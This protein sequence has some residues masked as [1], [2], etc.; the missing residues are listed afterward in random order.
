M[1]AITITTNALRMVQIGRFPV[2]TTAFQGRPLRLLILGAIV[3]IIA[4]IL[5]PTPPQWRHTVGL[6][7]C[8]IAGSPWMLTTFFRQR[9]G[10]YLVWCLVTIGIMVTLEALFR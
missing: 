4:T 2:E 9:V 5:L 1:A 7:L 8:V 10:I 6:T 3:L